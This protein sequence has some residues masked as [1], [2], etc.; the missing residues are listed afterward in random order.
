MYHTDVIVLHA[1]LKWNWKQRAHPYCVHTF[2]PVIVHSWLSLQKKKKKTN[3]K[4]HTRWHTDDQHSGNTAMSLT[5]SKTWNWHSDTLG[6]SRP[7]HSHALD[8]HSEHKGCRGPQIMSVYFPVWFLFPPPATQ[9]LQV[10]ALCSL[11]PRLDF[12]ERRNQKRLL[13]I[14]IFS[15]LIYKLK[16]DSIFSST[17]ELKSELFSFSTIWLLLLCTNTVH[18]LSFWQYKD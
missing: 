2:L 9:M 16:S 10:K 14:H 6:L 5:S 8:E 13:L 1:G 12:H 4:Q 15:H 17:H 18:K 3:Q 11:F 7:K